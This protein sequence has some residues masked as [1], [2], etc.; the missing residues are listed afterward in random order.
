[1]YEVYVPR[2]YWLAAA[3]RILAPSFM[4]KRL[5]KNSFTTATLA[6]QQST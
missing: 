6:D 5:M 2:Y 3:I 4:R 1:V